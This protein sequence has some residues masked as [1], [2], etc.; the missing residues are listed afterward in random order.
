MEKVQWS[1]VWP[2]RE[3]SSVITIGYFDGL[4][5][6]HRA[7]M[8]A[9]RTLADACGA[10]AVLMSFE[11]HPSHVLALMEPAL[12]I[13]GLREKEWIIRETGLTD[14]TVMMEFVPEL[15]NMEPE[16]FVED[17][18]KKNAN[19]V[20]I[21]IGE[22]FRFGKGNRGD[23]A[24]ML[25][26]CTRFEMQC[27]IV[28]EVDDQGRRISSSRIRELLAC[29][30]IE[31]ANHLLGR[32]YLML[33]TVSHGSGLGHREL[34]PTINLNLTAGRQYPAEGVYV[35]RTF[36]EDGRGFASVSNIGHNPTVRDGISLR[37]ETHLLD[38]D[39][40]LYAQPV[41]I[42][43]YRRLRSEKRFESIEKLREQLTQDIHSARDYFAGEKG[44][45]E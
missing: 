9:T 45:E 14:Q 33:G 31:Q 32:P 13:Y 23:A 36:T 3:S 15:M 4:H 10:K 25:Q 37:C 19:A 43:F 16:R 35:T 24:M 29:G 44:N 28:A 34:V 39:K 18:L 6:G 42:E 41:R 17:V 5:Q 22:N 27:Q 2:H 1:D 7:L 21:V 8:K 40:N 30:D 38:F 12:L 11:P 26:L 20:G